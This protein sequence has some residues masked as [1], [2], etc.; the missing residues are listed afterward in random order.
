MGAEL[1]I[2]YGYGK[3]DPASPMGKAGSKST[4]WVPGKN[5]NYYYF[6]FGSCSAKYVINNN[7]FIDRYRIKTDNYAK[8]SIEFTNKKLKGIL[9]KMALQVS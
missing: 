5:E 6:D 1:A 9:V 4:S 2:K 3:E 7:D 8:S